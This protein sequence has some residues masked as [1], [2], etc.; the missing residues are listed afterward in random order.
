MNGDDLKRILE[1]N[2]AKFLGQVVKHVDGRIDT[3]DTTLTD[4]FNRLDN[5][6]DGIAKRLDKDD[7]ERTAT[8]AQV[9][10]HETW[11]GQLADQTN[12]KLVPEQ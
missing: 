9:D 2:N 7:Q 6:L 10:R 3:L 5:S 12:T 11:I 4:R 8:E 1:E